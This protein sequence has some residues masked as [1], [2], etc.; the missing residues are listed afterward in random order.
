MKIFKSK[1]FKKSVIFWDVWGTRLVTL[2]NFQN[3]SFEI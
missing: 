2:K 3:F 1:K